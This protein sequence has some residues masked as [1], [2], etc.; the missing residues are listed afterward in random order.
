MM[1]P[2]GGNFHVESSASPIIPKDGSL[3]CVK[4]ICEYWGVVNGVEYLK[5][6]FLASEHMIS[7]DMPL[8]NH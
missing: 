6:A 8:Q 1:T 7:L 5:I 2:R 4:L 3:C